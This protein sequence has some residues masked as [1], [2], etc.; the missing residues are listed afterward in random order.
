M[1]ENSVGGQELGRYLHTISPQEH[2]N[3]RFNEA[4]YSNTTY[5]FL[6]SD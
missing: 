6:T 5:I 1:I 3:M 2:R 4:R